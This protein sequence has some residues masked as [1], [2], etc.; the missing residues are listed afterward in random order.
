[1]EELAGDLA[2][3][4]QEFRAAVELREK[5]GDGT[6]AGRHAYALARL[7]DL[8]GRSQDAETF[9]RIC[10]EA[11]EAASEDLLLQVERRCGRARVMARRGQAEEA[12]LLVQEAVALLAP[13]D[14]I[15]DRAL[16]LMDA[17]AVLSLAG[18]FEQAASLAEEALELYEQKGNL[19]AAG[20]ARSLVAELQAASSSAR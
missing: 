15:L 17:A 12:V 11:A 13:W 19:V 3:A 20:K 1:V 16:L 2:A 7:T 9:V 5:K 10:E 8:Q 6:G 4:E 14:A 18:R